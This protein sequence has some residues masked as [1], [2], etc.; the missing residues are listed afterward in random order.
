MPCDPCKCL[1]SMGSRCRPRMAQLTAQQ[2]TALAC[3]NQL[4]A[5]PRAW[6]GPSMHSCAGGSG[7]PARSNCDTWALICMGRA[8]AL[9]AEL[10]G[11]TS[12]C[13][14]KSYNMCAGTRLLKACAGLSCATTTM[15]NG[16][17]AGGCCLCES[18][19][20]VVRASQGMHVDKAC[21][22][23]APGLAEPAVAQR[24]RRNQRP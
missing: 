9:V 18:A 7:S 1:C 12:L 20:W 15:L 13:Q 21:C 3:Q 23:P 14:R 22:G 17:H 5:V 8:S 11:M 6:H 19:D 16:S 4:D 10:R 24:H 2:V